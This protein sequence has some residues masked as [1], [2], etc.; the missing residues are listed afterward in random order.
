MAVIHYLTATGVASSSFTQET[1]VLATLLCAKEPVITPTY[2]GQAPKGSQVV[3]QLG[4][5]KA[6][7]QALAGEALYAAEE[8]AK[9]LEVRIAELHGIVGPVWDNRA[10]PFVT[11]LERVGKRAALLGLLLEE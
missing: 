1:P 9:Q 7:A 11:Y 4:Q 3:M 8:S 6:I 2:A 5:P 10:L